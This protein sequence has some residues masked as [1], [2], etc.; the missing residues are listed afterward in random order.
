MILHLLRGEK[1]QVVWG[2][3]LIVVYHHSTRMIMYYFYERIWTSV[4]WGRT[5]EAGEYRPMSATEILLWALAI[6]AIVAVIFTAIIYVSPMLK[7]K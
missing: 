2:A 4:R 6:L 1:N 3:T 7:D 5:G